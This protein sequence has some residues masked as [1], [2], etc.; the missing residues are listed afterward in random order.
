MSEHP[1]TAVSGTTPLTVGLGHM[2]LNITDPRPGSERAYGRWYED[3]HF[4]SGAMNAPF[5]FSGRRWVAPAALRRL[6]HARAGGEYDGRDAGAYAA[7]YWIAPGHLND[8]FAWSAGSSPRLDA[9]GRGFAERDLIF[10]SFA[11]RVGTA[12]RDDDVPR[13]RFELI[14][15][16][17]GLVVQLIDAADAEERRAVTQWL[18]DD[19]IPARLAL[20]GT[21]AHSAV[22]FHGAADTSAMRPALRDLQSRADN[23]GRRILLLWFLDHDPRDT[24]AEEFA[25]LPELIAAGGRAAVEWSAPFIPAHMGTDLYVDELGLQR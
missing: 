14:D 9:E 6:Q 4:F 20:P 13:D 11:D 7:T 8:Y 18:A 23:A 3:D 2:L 25:P 12:Y 15:P 16:A 24:W 19:L 21:S 22:M 10:V 17:G 5:V 1:L